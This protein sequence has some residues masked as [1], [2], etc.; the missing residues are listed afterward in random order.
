MKLE[1]YVL[2]NS[3]TNKDYLA[4]Y[5]EESKQVAEYIFMKNRLLETVC[6]ENL[7]QQF[8]Q[9]FYEPKERVETTENEKEKALF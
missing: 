3:K 9:V 2:T 8:R 1:L 6:K 7:K 5:D 4:I